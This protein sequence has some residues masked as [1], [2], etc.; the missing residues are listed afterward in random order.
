MNRSE[1]AESCYR[2]PDGGPEH[3]VEPNAGGW[4]DVTSGRSGQVYR[5]DTTGRC[6]CTGWEY[7]GRCSHVRAVLEHAAQVLR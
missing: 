4:F 7:Y 3:T 1:V 2:A 6:T 5:V